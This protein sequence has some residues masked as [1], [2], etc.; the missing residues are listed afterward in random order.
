[1]SGKLGS[2]SGHAIRVHLDNRAVKVRCVRERTFRII[3]V[4]FF[5]GAFGTSV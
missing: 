5:H 4:R 1:M 2:R 3:V